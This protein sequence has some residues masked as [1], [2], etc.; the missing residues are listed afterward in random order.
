MCLLFRQLDSVCI[1]AACVCME[2]VLELVLGLV[3]VLALVGF[4]SGF[5][6]GYFRNPI[7]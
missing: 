7:A 1:A 2:L 4:A 3:L 5:P 6:E